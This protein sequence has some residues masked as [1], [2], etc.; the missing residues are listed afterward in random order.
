M[1]PHSQGESGNKTA[2]IPDA[3]DRVRNQL[4]NDTEGRLQMMR[5]RLLTIALAAMLIVPSLAMAATIEGTVQGLHCVVAGKTC[6]VG[7]EDPLIS[8]ERVFVVL[9]ADGNY[10][11]IPNLDRAVL[12]RHVTEKVRIEGELNGKHR[13]IVA[14]SMAVWKD[15][16]WKTVWSQK[17][18][19]ELS[20][21]LYLMGT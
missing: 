15:G 5:K 13:S 14:D 7:K 3:L 21:R 19:D 11:L 18:E 8:L 20:K 12:A 6:P 9:A 17:M 10:Y 1:I 4:M 16:K 2:K